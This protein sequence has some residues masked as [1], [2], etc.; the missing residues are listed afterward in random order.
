[1]LTKA[2]VLALLEER[3][4]RITAAAPMGASKSTQEAVL[5][6]LSALD[7]RHSHY[8]VLS[9]GEREE[10]RRV[11]SKLAEQI[12][13]R[14]PKNRRISGRQPGLPPEVLAFFGDADCIPHRPRAT[15]HPKREGMHARAWAGALHLRSVELNPP[16]QV[17]WLM[18][19][20]DHER[21]ELWR[22]AGLPEPSFITINPVNQHHHVVY[23]LKASVCRSERGR[24]RPRAFLRAVREGLR[25]ALNGDV[26]YNGLLTKNPLHPAWLTIRRTEM[27]SYSLAELA[28]PLNLRRTAT[29]MAARRQAPWQ[30]NL[31]EVGVGGRNRALFDTVRR[32]A[33][34][35]PDA[36]AGLRDYAEQCNALFPQPLDSNEV[37]DVAGS[38]ERYMADRRLSAGASEA[39]SARQAARGKLGGRPRTTMDSEPWTAEDICRSTWYKRCAKLAAGEGSP[40]HAPARRGR[41]PTTKDSE[42][43]AAEGISRATWYRRRGRACDAAEKGATAA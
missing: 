9:T 40:A 4:A 10:V 8:V 34:Q 16:A 35:N 2:E 43:W 24:S 26:S 3:H 31:A 20:C 41:P 39:F 13:A 23:R 42:P 21:Q 18:F 14:L 38:I 28:A 32:W 37:R 5:R 33:R 7:N 17:H 29:T 22:E 30:M 19:D 6:T 25:I 15:N 27:P 12:G 1:M 11:W 36:L